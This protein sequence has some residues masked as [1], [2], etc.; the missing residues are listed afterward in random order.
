MPTTARQPLLGPVQRESGRAS[1]L[2]A[3]RRNGIIDDHGDPSWPDVLVTDWHRREDDDMG[4]RQRLRYT[5][6]DHQPV[7][8]QTEGAP[9]PPS[10]PRVIQVGRA[11]RAPIRRT[12]PLS[13]RRLATLAVFVGF[14]MV[15]WVGAWQTM[16]WVWGL[17]R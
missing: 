4:I 5:V 16:Q 1:V 7:P 3:L 12:A 13:W 15:F 9:W 14:C 2:H 6:D 11:T 10:E 8:P 17:V